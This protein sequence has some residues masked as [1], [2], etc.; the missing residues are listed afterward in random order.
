[1]CS[2]IMDKNKI[3]NTTKRSKWSNDKRRERQSLTPEERERQNAI[4]R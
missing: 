4:R 3:Q 1:M 2:F